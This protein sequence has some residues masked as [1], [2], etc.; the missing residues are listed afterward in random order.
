MACQVRHI[1]AVVL[2][3]RNTN[4]TGMLKFQIFVVDDRFK[5][6]IVLQSADERKVVIV[7]FRVL[8]RHVAS[9][10]R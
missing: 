3:P 9:P 2:K 7:I 6:T 5:V 10:P 1:R 4:V 8:V